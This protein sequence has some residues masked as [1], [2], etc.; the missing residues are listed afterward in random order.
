VSLDAYDDAARRIRAALAA[1][2]PRRAT[3]HGFGRAAV[4]VTVLRRPGG[5]TLLFTRRTESLKKHRGEISFPGGHLEGSESA[6]A[7]ALREADEEVALDPARVEVAGELDDRPSVTRIMV[8]PVVGL[9]PDPPVGFHRDEREVDEVFEVPLARFLAPDAA[10][11][12]WWDASRLP[13]DA[14]RRPLLDLGSEEVDGAGRYAVYFFDVA[15]DRVIWGLTARVVK[16]LVRR[17]LA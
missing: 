14:P 9:V 17:A 11:V 15:P 16:D 10:R 8:T 3:I 12:E 6:R 5:P 4:L 13:A 7:A 2:P 1:R